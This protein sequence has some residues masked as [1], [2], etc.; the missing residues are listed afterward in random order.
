[1]RIRA[2]I[3]VAIVP[4]FVGLTLVT[5]AL[6]YYLQ[7]KELTWGLS[8][9]STSIAVATARLI[10]VAALKRLAAGERAADSAI[11]EQF[12]QVISWGRA[13][14]L[15]LLAG[16]DLRVLLE[17]VDGSPDDRV[18]EVPPAV[19]AALEH[20]PFATGALLQGAT[21]SSALTAFAPVRDAAGTPLGILAVETR[22]DA[23]GSQRVAI[24]R[25][26]LISLLA[27]ALLALLLTVLISTLIT[28]RLSALTRR[29]L[30]A[31]TAGAVSEAGAGVIDEMNDLENTFDTMRSVLDEV[32]SKNRH[33]LIEAEQF[34]TDDDLANSYGNEFQ[35]PIRR[36]IA[37]MDVAGSLAGAR[38]SGSFF[39]AWSL[40]DGG[41]AFVGTVEKQDILEQ[42]VLAV[43][44]LACLEQTSRSVGLGR[45]LAQ[46]AEFFPLV[47][48]DGVAWREGGT[49]AVR[50]S[51]DWGAGEWRQAPVE[52]PAGAAVVLH[53]MGT[54]VDSRIHTYL[55][56]FR[57]LAPE[58]L[59]GE[60]RVLVDERLSGA[61]LL[62]RRA[63][64]E[65]EAS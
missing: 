16:A 61:L 8:E 27:A 6:T 55:E 5:G 12:R 3:A 53:T 40:P 30:Q 22:A 10:D 24:L 33:R 42:A 31:E 4:L 63:A 59:L 49:A 15:T 60:I 19:V 1:M 36:T 11:R 14:R 23:L 64:I 26:V 28:R 2:Q 62:A 48:C 35:R 21:G 9:E 57:S 43:A 52:L 65:A 56:Q 41:C 38:P 54:H 29:L 50:W 7:V 51:F 32:L 25:S 17:V 39:G 37:G 58:T 44:A 13:R 20:Q 18:V 46:T 34:R 45:A 47:L